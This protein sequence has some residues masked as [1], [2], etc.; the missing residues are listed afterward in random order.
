MS[1]PPD[2]LIAMREPVVTRHPS[3]SAARMR[4][5][6]A[7][8]KQGSVLVRLQIAATGIDWLITA[9]WL[10]EADRADRDKVGLAVL[11][12]ADAAILSNLRCR[13]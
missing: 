1:R 9:G 3:P 6:R 12:L 11:G 10:H 2:A 8:R 5:S 4:R 7:R 13:K